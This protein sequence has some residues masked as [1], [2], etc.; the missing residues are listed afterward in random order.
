MRKERGVICRIRSSEVERKVVLP[1]RSRS[2]VAGQ[3]QLARSPSPV[4]DARVKKDNLTRWFLVGDLLTEVDDTSSHQH[5]H[6][7]L[8]DSAK[9]GRIFSSGNRQNEN[10]RSCKREFAS[11]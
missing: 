1:E 5:A 4:A 2:H 9:N 7:K 3:E 11:S 10:S 6:Q 8:E